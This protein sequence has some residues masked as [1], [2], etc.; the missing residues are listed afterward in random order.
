MSA[1]TAPDEWPGTGAPITPAASAV[2]GERVP[3]EPDDG[4][5]VED[6]AGD[7]FVGL[8]D[9]LA[10]TFDLVGY[11]SLLTDRL[12]HLLGGAD[13]GVFMRDDDGHIQAVASSSDRV[14][15]VERFE[16]EH[17]EGACV[18]SARS[19]VAVV[20]QRLEDAVERWPRFV[21]R[22]LEAGYHMVST[23]PMRLR[24]EVIGSVNVFHAGAIPLQD[25]DL[26]RAQAFADAATI[27]ILHERAVGGALTRVAQL[28]H[29]LNSRIVIEQAKGL[30]AGQ[31][32]L[33]VREAFAVLRNYARAHRRRLLDVAG[34]ITDRSLPSASL[35]IP[36]AGSGS[37][38]PGASWSAAEEDDPGDSPPGGL[39]GQ[40][41]QRA[42]SIAMSLSAIRSLL[43][44]LAAERMDRSLADLDDLLRDVRRASFVGDGPGDDGLAP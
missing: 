10:G 32:D 41:I 15:E 2:P 38:E 43:T 8:A 26:L 24:D 23:L 25:R 37:T 9:T 44:G 19:G 42:S 36:A 20:N 3:A 7:I 34:D 12:A 5:G 39:A 14:R 28:E 35:R 1:L 30:V 21:P 40:V 11:L 13:V 6:W 16:L 22:T 31:L 17:N 29:A 18:Y 27:G 4:A 33:S